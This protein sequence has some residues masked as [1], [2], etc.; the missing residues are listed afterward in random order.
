M[1]RVKKW[2]NYLPVLM[3][4][5]LAVCTNVDEDR[6]V[7]SSDQSEPGPGI[8]EGITGRVTN[9]SNLPVKGALVQPRSLE[10]PSPPIPEIAILTDGEGRYKW[11]LLPGNY[12]IS[13]SFKGCQRAARRVKIEVGQEVQVDFILQC[14]TDT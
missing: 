3:L 14:E 13:V 5:G 8:R 6:L 7:K 2:R 1:A 11:P 9:S 10:D 12:E 4:C